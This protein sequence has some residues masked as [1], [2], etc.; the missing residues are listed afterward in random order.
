MNILGEIV[1][2]SL[3]NDDL[4]LGNISMTIDLSSH[5]KGIYFVKILLPARNSS[6]GLNYVGNDSEIF[7]VKKII[8]N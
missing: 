6:V 1:H 2:Q 5:P 3:V 4:T 8:V 7:I